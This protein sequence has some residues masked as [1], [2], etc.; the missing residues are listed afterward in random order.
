MTFNKVLK[1]RSVKQGNCIDFFLHLKEQLPGISL[2]WVW[3]DQNFSS[4][5]QNSLSSTDTG[6][7]TA[8]PSAFYKVIKNHLAINKWVDFYFT[9]ASKNYHCKAITIKPDE[10]QST[11]LLF[12]EKVLSLSQHQIDLTELC[13]SNISYL[14]HQQDIDLKLKELGHHMLYQIVWSE[15]LEWIGALEAEDNNFYKEMMVRVLL[16]TESSASAIYI[17]AE[18][19]AP[20]WHYKGISLEDIAQIE[21]ILKH[22]KKDLYSLMVMED[23]NNLADH[24]SDYSVVKQHAHLF[25]CPIIDPQGQR[26]AIIILSKKKSKSCYSLTDHVYINQLITQTFTGIEKNALVKALENSN[27]SLEKEHNA[28]KILI[29]KL[30]D[31]QAQLLQSEKMSSIGQ[32][33][34]GVAHEI[35]NPIGFVNS[36]LSTLSEFSKS[37]LT[38]IQA[39]GK[40]I[41]S[42]NDHEFKAFY[43]QLAEK[44][45]IDFITEDLFSLLEESKEGISRVKDIV[46]DLKDFSRT[47]SGEF[48]IVDI[49]HIIDKTLNLIHNE[50]KYTAD[51]ITDYAELPEVEVVESQ[52]GQ[53]ILN[54]LVNA[55]HAIDEKGF[56]RIVTSVNEDKETIQISVTDSG[57]GINPK[58]ISKLFDPFFTT[59]PVGK[60]TGLG[61]SL[62]YGIIQRHHGDIE[63]E[64]ELGVGSTFTVT[65]PISQPTTIDNE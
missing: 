62:S 15:S 44:N 65:L 51:L 9:F 26:K 41:A 50:I 17:E 61:L 10:Q 21:E 2:S 36:N 34:A 38:V 12:S 56:I 23:I 11:L 48:T 54:L 20:A 40:K 29:Q 31:A 22:K 1:D 35:N 60:G 42:G 46:Q 24:Y 5:M 64:S 37:M 14:R 57:K 43:D 27:K 52:I 8:V 28:Q 59:K 7:L 4:S 39:L 13:L 6:T 33:A 63:V 32:L 53:V 47:D 58:H 45:E 55:S 49:K 18:N 16:L 30:Q 19:Q 3:Y 25:L